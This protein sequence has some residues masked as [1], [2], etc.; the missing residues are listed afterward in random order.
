[1]ISKYP[2]LI[3]RSVT[4]TMTERHFPK[5]AVE[6]IS[7][8]ELD[9]LHVTEQLRYRPPLELLRRRFRIGTVTV[10]GDAMHAMGPFLAQGGSASLE[11]AV[12]LGRCLARNL[13]TTSTSSFR[14]REMR[15][16]MVRNAFDEYVKERRMRVF[17]LSMETYLIGMMLDSSSVVVK[18][19]G[20]VLMCIVFRDPN[21]HTR[22]NCGCL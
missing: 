17:R 6:M 20:I 1:M 8:S 19:I 18:F 22:Y 9:S 12:V 7:K 3:K 15:A 2:G 4:E 21:G 13:C 11:D 16:L 5:E 10:A 14:G